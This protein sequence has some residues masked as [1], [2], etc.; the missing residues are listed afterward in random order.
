MM[1][2]SQSLRRAALMVFA[3]SAAILLGAF[4][5]QYIGGLQPCIL[6]WW[7]RYPYMATIVLALF[8]VAVAPTRP[9]LARVVL[10]LS[11]VA[12]LVGAGIA[13][14]HVGVEQHWWAGTA[15]CGANF[16]PAGSVEELR[17]RLLAQNVV[18]CDDIAWSLFGISMAGYNF[19]LS[20]ALAVFAVQAVRSDARLIAR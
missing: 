3:S 8:A 14:F 17:R 18:R 16:G 5:F 7:Q 2:E 12:F 6:C 13:A 9:K 4:A 1:S 15:E 10:G 20:L 11:A 19:L